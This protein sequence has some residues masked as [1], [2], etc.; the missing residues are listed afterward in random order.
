MTPPGDAEACAIVEVILGLAKQLALDVIAEGV[1]TAE[2]ARYLLNHGCTLLQGYHYARP[3][4]AHQVV[5]LIRSRSLPIA[6]TARSSL[7]ND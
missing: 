4:S 7:C 3:I 5:D 2:Q 6:A 1:E